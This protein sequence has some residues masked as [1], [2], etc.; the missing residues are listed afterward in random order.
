MDPLSIKIELYCNGVKLDEGISLE[1]KKCIIPTRVYTNKRA[2]LSNG[3]CFKLNING[4]NTIANLA[5]RESFASNSPYTF[6]ERDGKGYIAGKGFE[7]QAEPIKSPEWT[8]IEISAGKKV[9]HIMQQHS[10]HIL[11]TALS[12]FCT[13]KIEGKGCKFCALD[14]GHNY[15]FKKPEEIREVLTALKEKGILGKDIL[16]IN[17]NSG[18]MENEEVSAESYLEAIKTMKEV[19]N[20]PV[21]AQLCPVDG[22]M[23]ERLHDAGLDSISFNIEIYDETIRK[24]ICPGKGE[25]PVSRYLESL[26]MASS[27]FGKNQTSS[28]L[29]VGLESPES[30]IKGM[31]EIAKAGAIPHLTV[32]RPLEGTEL[33]KIAPP[34]PQKIIRIY[35]ELPRVLNQYG[36]NPL[37]TRS[38]C[39][40]CN[41][42]SATL[43]AIMQDVP[44]ALINECAN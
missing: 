15:V 39:T 12:N 31:E 19:S 13:Y 38:G 10:T 4:Y 32:F 23:I 24:E 25:I 8:E 17:I 40:K 21:Y 27:I 1:T 30:S 41:G 37:E 11:G 9:V 22:K 3:K 34:D 36:L 44:A 42:C 28:W 5:V 18:V 16:E 35:K 7:I 14:A 43:E 2:S 20:L 33:A 6:F 29:I 26:S